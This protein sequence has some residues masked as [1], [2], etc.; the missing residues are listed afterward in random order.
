M[1]GLRGSGRGWGASSWGVGREVSREVV[2]NLELGFA[3]A[4][5]PLLLPSRFLFFFLVIRLFLLLL[6]GTFTYPPSRNTAAAFFTTYE[7]LK[8]TLPKNIDVLEQ[9][10]AANHLVS[11]MGAEIVSHFELIL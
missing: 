6:A 2:V 9:A 11:S 8:R 5:Q 7:Y 1:G 4:D 10:P 3:E